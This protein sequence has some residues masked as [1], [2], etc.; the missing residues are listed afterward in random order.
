MKIINQLT[1]RYLKENKKR[2]VLTILCITV[3]VIMISCVGIAFYS[4]KQFYK[5]YTEKTVGDYHYAFV[6][7][8][9][10]FLK[11]IENDDQIEEYYFSSTEA[12]YSDKQLKDKSFMNLKRGDSL[13]FEKEYYKDSIISGRLPNNYGEIVISENY[14]KLNNFHKNIGDEIQ[15]YS[16]SDKNNYSFLIV[17]IMNDYNSENINKSSFNA[18]SYI[19]LNNQE[20]YYSLYIRD[21][22]VSNQ[23]FEHSEKL[24]HQLSQ[25][26]NNQSNDIRYNSSYLAIQDVFEENSS[27][28]FLVI[29]NMVAMILGII[30]FIS[31]FIIYQ[32]FNLS[33][34]DRIQ[35]LGM[36]SSVGAT[37]KQKRRSVYFEGL[38]LSVFAI[39][40]G[41]LLS[42]LGLYVTFFFINHLETIQNLNIEIYPQ[43]SLFYLAIVIL[44]SFMTIFM[45]LYLPA[46]K[47][48][49]ISVIDALKKNDE[50]KVK[51]HKLKTSFIARKFLNI[52][53]QLAIK[54][55]KRQGKRSRVIVISLVISMV[56]FIA[57]YSFG[58][59]FMKQ[60]NK[61]NVYD[62][63]DIQM[64]IGADK[65]YV[66]ETNKI[67]NQND[68][69]D[70]YYY[71]TNLDI[72]ADIDKSYVNVPI[73]ADASTQK[74]NFTLIGLSEN[75]RRQLCS[76]NQIEYQKNQVLAYNGKY[77]DF[78]NDKE[79]KQRF[80]KIDKN[81]LKSMQVIHREYDNTGEVI[82][83][84]TKI[85]SLTPF[86]SV[87]MI[88]KDQFQNAYEIGNLENS[89]Y[90]I[91]P[92]EYIMDAETEY[93]P[94]ITYNIFS[95]QHQ[96]LTKELKKLNYSPYDFAQNVTENRQIF[97]IIQ[98]FIYGFV[99]IMILFTMLNIINMMSASIDKRKKELGMMLSVG[100]SPKDIS[101]MLFYESFIYGL[102]TFLY[103]LPICIGIEW[104]FFDQMK[105]SDMIFIPSLVAYMIA[106]IVIVIVMLITFRFGLNK[107][108]KQNIIETLK[109][110]M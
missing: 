28:S 84:E 94:S 110:D 90:F 10:E 87:T 64:S 85:T 33:T 96:E 43:I 32:A 102:K 47:I 83:T 107:F 51:N 91:V 93:L 55:Y 21:K 22:V 109:D 59:N 11:I 44:I 100:M 68:K 61:S 45:S 5:E 34:N 56:A 17:G 54:N 18:L 69:V 74:Y 62:R 15:F 12:L 42:F 108:K 48:S 63:Y 105:T 71:V 36:L 52:T 79:Y 8:N 106:F 37:P 19:N 58:Q 50:I 1:L 35:Y 88:Q 82:R 67:L 99:C 66:Q 89:L 103:G 97:L 13:Y 27:S 92:V 49:K 4:G 80:N 25:L 38:L 70:E 101:K 23:I 40:L 46:R 77:V 41:I 75:K 16:D 76:D 26:E 20:S 57:M 86:E 2:T 30:V 53:Q 39:P 78:E 24:D 81:F 31:L 6:S 3:S 7:S 98:I 9:K 95:S 72:Y 104:M 29:Y 60:V 14:L 65:D 73:T